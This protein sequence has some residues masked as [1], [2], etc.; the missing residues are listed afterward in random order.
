MSVPFFTF[1]LLT[2]GGRRDVDGRRCVVD[3]VVPTSQELRTDPQRTCAPQSLDPSHLR[4][5]TA[6]EWRDLVKSLVEGCY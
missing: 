1:C 3:A 5:K 2:P 4:E 6:E